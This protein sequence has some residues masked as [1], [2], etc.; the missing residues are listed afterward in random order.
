MRMV[1]E[2]PKSYSTCYFPPASPHLPS[3]EGRSAR[4]RKLDVPPVIQQHVLR[5]QIPVHDSHL[6]VQVVQ[7]QRDLRH[8]KLSR[9]C[10]KK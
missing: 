5:L 9:R 10:H 6:V 7:G 2:H 3:I 4:T 8:V 1:K